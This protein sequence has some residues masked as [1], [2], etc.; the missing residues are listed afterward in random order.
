MKFKLFSA[1]N[2]V[3][4]NYYELTYFMKNKTIFYV[5]TGLSIIINQHKQTML[6]SSNTFVHRFIIL[7][8]SKIIALCCMSEMKQRGDER[9]QFKMS[10]EINKN[11]QKEFNQ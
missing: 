7:F 9:R 6:H 2:T 11:Y 5:T 10:F 1:M 3:F 8:L 4:H